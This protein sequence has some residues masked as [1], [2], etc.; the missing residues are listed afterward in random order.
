M[1]TVP[2]G[3]A[4]VADV[5][6][7]KREQRGWYFYDWANSAF[8]TS[9][10]TV[11]GALYTGSVAAQDARADIARN[12][13]TPC[14][15]AQGAEN[16]LQNCDITLF[17]LAFPAGSLWGYLLSAATVIQVLI[18]PITGAIAD[19]SQ[20]KKRILGAFAFVGAT[21]SALLFF[22]ADG[23]WELGVVLY[24]IAN[25]GY[26]AS[27]V[28]Y[29]SFLPDIATPDER[30]R[31]SARG[32]AFG[33]LGGGLALALQL[34]FYLSRDAFGVSESL[35]VRICF[36]SAG[37]WWG[38]F[39]LIPLRRLHEHQPPHGRERG[40]S[41]VRAGFSELWQTLRAARAFPLTLA[42]LGAYLVFTDGISTVVAVSAQYGKD[43]LKF[44][45]EVLITTILV[46]QFVAYLGG[47]LHGFVAQRIGAKKTI[48]GSL[49]VWIVVIC[50]AYFIQPGKELQFYAVAGGIGLVLGGTNALSRS[51]Y[52][53][54]IPAGKEAQYYSLYEIGERG[55]SWLGP[56]LF[57]GV[58]HATGS[59]RYAIVALAVFFV[60]GFV[61][62]ALVPVRRA[63][64]AAG[65]REPA[66]L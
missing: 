38:L 25:V 19:R 39:T 30:D 21:A 44:A 15:D 47:M 65:N 66:V 13:P 34:A 55:T 9:V 62:V 49:L 8:Y 50:A 4:P 61:L 54:M 58:G 46:I 11:F 36:L 5:R 28:V 29:Y 2:E 35:A 45:N 31:V 64:A 37:L 1:T 17:G 43:E 63:I 41:I 16:T 14:V 6:D 57:A 10:I 51:L 18:L 7:R 42:F 32:W 40:A 24:V 33:Y 23:R 27:I 53:Q 59:F 26:G 48:L 52:S 12:G 60:A 56:L 22:L 3:P 20:Y